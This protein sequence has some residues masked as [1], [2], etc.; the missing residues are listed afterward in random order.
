[1]SKG[2]SYRSRLTDLDLD[3][4]EFPR[5]PRS[6]E[7]DHTGIGLHVKRSLWQ[8]QRR[9]IIEVGHVMTG[10]MKL[11][12]FLIGA[13][14]LRTVGVDERSAMLENV[15]ARTAKGPGF[16]SKINII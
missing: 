16:Q 3:R 4:I 11:C 10:Q 8:V 9:D 15:L 1:M 12:G 14:W 7:V 6:I 13:H 2:T 5:L